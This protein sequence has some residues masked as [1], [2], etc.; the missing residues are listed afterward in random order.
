MDLVDGRRLQAACLMLA[1]EVG[2][3]LRGHLAHGHS[4]E[5]G[6]D[7][8]PVVLLVAVDRVRRAALPAQL[9]DP[10]LEHLVDR[11]CSPGVTALPDLDQELGPGHSRIAERATERAAHLPALPGEEVLT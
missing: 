7:V 3:L 8:A 4:P 11:P 9:D 2:E 6:P 1:V 10:V 5:R